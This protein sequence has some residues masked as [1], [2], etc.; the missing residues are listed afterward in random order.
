M[1]HSAS[2]S[3]LISSTPRTR[4]LFSVSLRGIRN[5]SPREQTRSLSPTGAGL[6]ASTA[7]SPT[8]IA[9]SPFSRGSCFGH[10]RPRRAR[11]GCMAC[12]WFRSRRPTR[13]G[14]RLLPPLARPSTASVTRVSFYRTIGVR[15]P[16]EDSEKLG[17]AQRLAVMP[18]LVRGRRRAVSSRSFAVVA[19]PCGRHSE[20]R[21]RRSLQS[22]CASDD[23]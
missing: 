18:S 20:L 7:A 21:Q 9:L 23:R 5:R 8:A 11:K 4:R 16:G 15:T 22:E 12:S 2:P 14:R 3:R 6:A 13:P 1:R 17:E 19:A 10:S